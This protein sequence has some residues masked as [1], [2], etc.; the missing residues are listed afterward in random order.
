[1]DLLELAGRAV[2][3]LHMLKHAGMTKPTF[4]DCREG[5]C[6]DWHKLKE[7]NHGEEEKSEGKEA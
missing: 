1:M 4:N 7:A 5:L 2:V 6:D 3:A